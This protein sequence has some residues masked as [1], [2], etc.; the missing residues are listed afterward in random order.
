MTQVINREYVEL[1][2]N[3]L[4]PHPDNF[5]VGDS[6]SISESIG[7][8]GFFG[9]VLAREMPDGSY[10]ILA[11]RHRWAEAK[12]HGLQRVPVIVVE[13]D[14]EAALKI[15]A[16]DNETNRR[17]RYDRAKARRVLES[18]DDLKGTGFDLSGLE[19]LEGERE[20][21]EAASEPTEEPAAPAEPTPQPQFQREY[22]V[23]VMCVD[24][25]AQEEAYN[26]LLDQFD[27]SRLKVVSI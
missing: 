18:L 13:A 21:E 27:E 3:T 17:G 20:A 22:G 7:V 19:A 2:V 16:A 1:D 15:L 14:D 9:A 24:E 11:G 12:E 4:E 8:N 10:Q 26:A 5:N 25:N 6:A 23:L